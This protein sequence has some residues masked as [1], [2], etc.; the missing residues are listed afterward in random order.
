MDASVSEPRSQSSKAALAIFWGG[1]IAGVLDLIYATASVVLKGYPAIVLPQAIATGLLGAKSFQGGV[2]T[3]VLGIALEFLITFVAA[4]VYYGASRRLTFLTRQ[5][6]LWGLLYGIA[7]YFF[8]NFIVVPLSAAP[9]FKHTPVSIAS[10]FVVHM[11]F[12][13]LPMALAVRRYSARE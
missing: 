2:P 12:I 3:A 6:V 11:V 5:A 7:I 8:M 9:K 10:D 1:L 4:A 13:G